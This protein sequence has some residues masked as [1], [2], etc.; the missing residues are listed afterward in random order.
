MMNTRFALSTLALAGLLAS[1][2]PTSAA[3]PAAPAD[4]PATDATVMPGAA[5]F[6]SKKVVAYRITRGDKLAVQVFNEPDLTAGNKHVDARGMINLALIGDVSVY[7]LT[8]K[9]AAEA[10]KNAY[11]DGRI[12]RKPEVTVTVEEYSERTVTVVGK[13]KAPGKIQLPPEEQWTIKDVIVK[14]GGFDDT[15]RGTGVIV[16]RKKPDG[17]SE[18]WKIDVESAILGKDTKSN[19]AS[20]IVEP[21]DDFTGSISGATLKYTKYVSAPTV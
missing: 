5:R 11:R 17:T 13:V 14:A 9:D 4:A 15:A 7:G 3:E 8:L 19:E 1:G 21:G 16:T 6:D 2:L 12:L 20:F 10:I 18:Q